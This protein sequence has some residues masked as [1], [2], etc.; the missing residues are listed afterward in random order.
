VDELHQGTQG[1]EGRV[2]TTFLQLQ[3]EIFAR[4]ADYLDT[5]SDIAR[6]KT[7]LNSAYFDMC[8]REPWPFLEVTLTGVTAPQTITDLRGILSVVDTST[9]TPL[10]GIDRRDL[11]KTFVDLTQTGFD[12]YWYLESASDGAGGLTDTVK[13]FPVNASDSLEIRYIKVPSQLV[14]D[15]DIPV[16]PDRFLDSL[17]DGTMTYVHRDNDDYDLAGQTTQSFEQGIQLMADQLLNRNWMNAERQFTTQWD[18]NA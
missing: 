10:E 16:I 2:S 13:L 7:W 11:S 17:I 12:G 4:G 14:N 3:T 9:L 8:G 6:V 5:T 15:T 18:W 1:E